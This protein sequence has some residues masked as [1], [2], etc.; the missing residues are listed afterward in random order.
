MLCIITP[1]IQT[2]VYKDLVC[3]IDIKERKKMYQTANTMHFVWI[4]LFGALMTMLSLILGGGDHEIDHDTDHEADHSADAGDGGNMSFLSFKV[5]WMF[6]V[7]FG[8][9]GFAVARTGANVMWSATGGIFGGLTMA[10]LGYVLMNY[11][12]KHQ[13]NSVV[14]SSSVVGLRGIVDTPIL[15]GK[16][17][18]VR[19]VVDGHSEFFQASSKSTSPIPTSAQVIVVDANGS[20]LVVEP[21]V[22]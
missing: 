10:A 21:F 5:L 4:A 16:M 14:R 12:W 9:G 15:P 7:G 11:L 6:L 22:D 2:R 8:A 18:E 1:R 17:G 3:I 13:G 19:C 20:T